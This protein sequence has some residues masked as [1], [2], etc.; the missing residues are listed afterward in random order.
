MSDLE[1]VFDQVIEDKIRAVPGKA[2]VIETA[3]GKGRLLA[4]RGNYD[5]VEKVLPYCYAAQKVLV[6]PGDIPANLNDFDVIFV[7]CP[8]KVNVKAWGTVLHSFLDA[9]GVLLTTDWCL[10]HLIEK[11]FPQSL[12]VAGSAQ[13]TFPLRVRQRAHP[14]LEGISNCDGT[15]WVVETASHRIGIVDPKHVEVILDAPAMGEPAAVL[16]AFNVGKGMVV[17]AISHFHLQ[18][19][20]KSGEYISAYILTNVIDE[21]IRRRYLGDTGAR[22]RVVEAQEK[23]RPLRIKVL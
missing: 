5:Y 11:L 21:A 22:I 7:G 1:K 18:G 6:S 8:G 2:K 17:H 3:R 23:T 9:G 10:E 16:V 13:G 15:P 19:S 12:K 20:D 14:L 4:V